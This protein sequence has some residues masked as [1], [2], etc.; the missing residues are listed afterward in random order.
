MHTI[1]FFLNIRTTIYMGYFSVFLVMMLCTWIR[2]E[3]DML[4]ESHNLVMKLTGSVLIP[5]IRP[6]NGSR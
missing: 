6:T 5:K 3:R 1:D 4:S 2:M